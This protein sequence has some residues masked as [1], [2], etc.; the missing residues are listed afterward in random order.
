MTTVVIGVVGKIASGKSTVSKM[1]K[2][3]LSKDG[4]TVTYINTDGIYKSEVMSNVHYKKS[5]SEYFGIKDLQ[6]KSEVIRRISKMNIKEYSQL[7]ALINLY[8]SPSLTSALLRNPNY[9]IVESATLLDSPLAL[10]CDHILELD[11][12]E[13]IRKE[14]VFKRDG[15]IRSAEDTLNLMKLQDKFLKG[16]YRIRVKNKIFKYSPSVNSQE[17]SLT[18][19]FTHISRYSAYI[20]TNSNVNK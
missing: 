7:L 3:L 20:S 13:K 6:D 5:I 15:N 1:L 12:P 16:S 2:E 14:Y 11:I 17:Y 9:I 8:I 10:Q 19:M 18:V 4:K